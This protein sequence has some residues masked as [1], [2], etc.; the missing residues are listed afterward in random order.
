[1]SRFISIS[2]LLFLAVP[3]L[4]QRPLERGEILKDGEWKA[5]YDG[6]VPDPA[7]VASLK[8]LAPEMRIDVYL[9]FWCGDS[10]DHV[11][12]FLKIVDALESPGLQVNFFAVERKATPGLRFYVEGPAV[13][14]VPTFIFYRSDGVEKGRIVETP[15]VSILED[16]LTI[17]LQ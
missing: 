12:V 11:P 3:A 15:R 4:G 5:V 17:M 10:K 7:L 13:E 16:M 6:C 2:L 1:M 14:R 8:S 9:G